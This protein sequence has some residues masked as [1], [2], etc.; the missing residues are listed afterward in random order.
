M[1]A[2]IHLFYRAFLLTIHK[3]RLYVRLY[4]L[5]QSQLRKLSL[6]KRGGGSVN[7]FIQS[8]ILIVSTRFLQKSALFLQIIALHRLRTSAF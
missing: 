7:S 5:L 8:C 1:G 2:R 3:V 6:Y 4:G